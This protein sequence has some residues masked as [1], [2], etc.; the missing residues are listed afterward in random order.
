MAPPDWTGSFLVRGTSQL[1]PDVLQAPRI[2]P[3][4]L[5]SALCLCGHVT[6]TRGARVGL[7]GGT[8]HEAPP[9]LLGGVRRP[10]CLARAW[11]DWTFRCSPHRPWGHPWPC[12][13]PFPVPACP[14]LGLP[15]H[16]GPAAAPARRGS[17]SV[18]VESRPR[19]GP[20]RLCLSSGLKRRAHALR[21]GL[22]PPFTIHQ[23]ILLGP[24]T[25]RA[26]RPGLQQGGGLTGR[27]RINLVCGVGPAPQ[28]WAC[29]AL[30]PPWPPFSHSG[31]HSV[32]GAQCAVR[33]Q[34]LPLGDLP[35]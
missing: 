1:L 19:G 14:Q 8:L 22:T 18:A 26:V 6:L 28:V 3:D 4:P 23:N 17:L 9:A 33:S 24:D 5:G 34:V 7:V 27:P 32:D 13:G 15:A 30:H 12:Q 16:L 20:A 2:T 21:D 29:R 11:E 10:S 35:K 25:S 31:S